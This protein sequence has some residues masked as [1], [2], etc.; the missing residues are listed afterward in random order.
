MSDETT[1]G[2]DYE[3]RVYL[4]MQGG[5][6]QWRYWTEHWFTER[7]E[8]EIVAMLFEEAKHAYKA[9][10]PE[11]EPDDYSVGVERLRPADNY[12]PSGFRIS[13]AGSDE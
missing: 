2:Q 3:Y 5:P 1:A 13:D 12:R 4:W 6:K 7:P 9:L 10:F 11:T 8:P